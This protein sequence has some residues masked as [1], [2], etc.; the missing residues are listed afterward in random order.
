MLLIKYSDSD[1]EYQPIPKVSLYF[2]HAEIADG[3]DEVHLG[4]SGKSFCT[5]TGDQA[6]KF[7]EEI[8]ARGFYNEITGAI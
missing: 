4:K 7:I 8:E 2:D 5:L 3:G 1:Y 6:D